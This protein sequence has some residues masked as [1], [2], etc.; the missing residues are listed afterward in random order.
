MGKL[1]GNNLSQYEDILK[2][3]DHVK[4]KIARHQL[5]LN[6]ANLALMKLNELKDDFA[7]PAEESNEKPDKMETPDKIDTP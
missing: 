4:K 7:R 5:D 1:E 3:I 2:N 6:E